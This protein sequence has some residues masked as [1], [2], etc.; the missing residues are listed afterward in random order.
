M[1]AVV[2]G[3][4][5][6]YAAD[7]TAADATTTFNILDAHFLQNRGAS[8]LVVI[9]QRVGARPASG[10][11]AAGIAPTAATTCTIYLSQGQTIECGGS[12][13]NVN[14]TGTGAGV[15]IVGFW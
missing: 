6:T 5:Y 2:P 9:R 15:Q 3:I 13:E 10:K 7:V 1:P 12:W 14:S 4:S 11:G 8:G